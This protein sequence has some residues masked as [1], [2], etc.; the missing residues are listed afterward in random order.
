MCSG[1]LVKDMGIAILII[2]I[3]INIFFFLNQ[4][5]KKKNHLIVYP[6]PDHIVNL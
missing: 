1:M 5:K 3:I 6:F 2:I 4:F